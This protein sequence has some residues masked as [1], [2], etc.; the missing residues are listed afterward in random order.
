MQKKMCKKLEKIA[1]YL[2][3]VLSIFVLSLVIAMFIVINLQI[4]SREFFTA[5]SWTEELSRF[6]L[7]WISFFA[8]AIAYRKG[9]HIAITFVVKSFKERPKRI[10]KLIMNLFSAAF[11]IVVIYYGFKMISIQTYQRSP[12]MQ[13]PMSI[14]YLCIPFSNIIMLYYALIEILECDFKRGGKINEC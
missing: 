4:I 9:A 3:S 13:I 5:F 2:N 14:V 10:I 6:L 8:S 11:F 12:A 1:D 7:I